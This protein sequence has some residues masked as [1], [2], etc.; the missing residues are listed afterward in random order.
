MFR[1][2]SIQALKFFESAARLNS[3]TKAAEENGVSQGAVSQ[4]IKNLE[5]RVGFSVFSREGRNIILTASG[6]ELLTS[7]I[8]NLSNIQRC[9]ELERRKQQN[10]EL[11]ISVLPG[12]A[13]RWLFPRLMMFNALHPHIKIEINTVSQPLDFDLY[14]A[15]AAIGYTANEHKSATQTPL[16]EEHIFPVC[17]VNFAQKHN[18]SIPLAD[19]SLY[20]IQNLPVVKDQTPLTSACPNTW[21]YWQQQVGLDTFNNNHDN[22]QSQ[23]NITLQLAELGHGIAIGRTSLVMD[24]LDNGALIAISE[25]KIINP[26]HYF[27]TRNP[28]ISMNEPLQLF[29]QW[30]IENCTK[31]TQYKFKI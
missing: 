31:I 17:S 3:F 15:H 29:E 10:N 6:Q 14:H 16:F 4:H 30:L 26:C 19:E 1:L 23:S 13:I 21:V 18:L 25:H 8:S 9:I 28:A 5:I 11:I 24:A 22:S 27:I 12:F 7:L 2:P 20:Q